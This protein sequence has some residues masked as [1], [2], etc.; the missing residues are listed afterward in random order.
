MALARGTPSAAT[1]A[2]GDAGE[3][4]ELRVDGDSVTA[5]DAA[6]SSRGGGA[7]SSVLREGAEDAARKNEHHVRGL[8]GNSGRLAL[9]DTGLIAAVGQW[10][11]A[12]GPAWQAPVVA[13]HVSGQVVHLG[14]RAGRKQSTGTSQEQPATPPK[15]A[16]EHAV[17]GGG[18]CAGGNRGFFA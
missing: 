16:K 9:P 17:W 11:W 1:G 5:E 3:V 4:T 14:E 7:H 13:G 10:G 6:K 2:A 15:E 12:A 8:V 18:G